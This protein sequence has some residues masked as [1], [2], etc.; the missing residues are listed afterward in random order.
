MILL[1]VA[2]LMIKIEPQRRCDEERYRNEGGNREHVSPGERTPPARPPGLRG[3]APIPR[4]ICGYD[5]DRR[6]GNLGFEGQQLRVQV[7]GGGLT[8]RWQNV[9]AT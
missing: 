6:G 8:V 3:R 4:A 1:I 5:R 7:F 2:Q 9:P